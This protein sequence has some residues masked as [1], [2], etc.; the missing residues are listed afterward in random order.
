M[1]YL[2]QS[3]KN[4]VVPAAFMVAPD[5]TKSTIASAKPNA[6]AIST[7]PE[8]DLIVVGVLG[9]NF[10]KNCSVRLGNEVIM[11]LPTSD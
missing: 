1:R 3:V 4:V 5:S 10:L 8:I 2:T 9:S 7:D 6:Q 11:R